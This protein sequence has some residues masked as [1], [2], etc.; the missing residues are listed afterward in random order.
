MGLLLDARK[1]ESG[2]GSAVI[3]RDHTSAG[4]EQGIATPAGPWFAV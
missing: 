3:A 4:A 2:G 1:A